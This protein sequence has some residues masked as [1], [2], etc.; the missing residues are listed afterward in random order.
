MA[1]TDLKTKET[2]ASVEEFINSI[3]NEQRRSDA[4]SLLEMFEQETGL[5]A[6]MWGPAIIGFGN[7]MLKYESGREFDWM[8][9]AFSPRKANLTIYFESETTH[10]QAFLQRLGKHKTSKACLYINRLSDINEDVLREMIRDSIAITD[11]LSGKSNR[12]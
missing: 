2:E 12:L 10:N 7:M 1:K 3:E 5:K 9:I 4:F 6:A 8:K 11:S